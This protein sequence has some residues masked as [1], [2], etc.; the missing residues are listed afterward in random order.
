MAAT[1]HR[2]DPSDEQIFL[3]PPDQDAVKH[4]K[5]R[6]RQQMKLFA[7][8]YLMRLRGI[9]GP[10]HQASIGET[11]YQSGKG[12]IGEQAA[13]KIVASFCIGDKLLEDWCHG[14]L[15]L[16]TFVIFLISQTTVLPRWFN[17]ADDELEKDGLRDW[18][19][20]FANEILGAAYPADNELLRLKTCLENIFKRLKPTYLNLCQK[21][22]KWSWQGVSEANEE[23]T[24]L[25]L[26]PDAKTN[27]FIVKAIE[28]AERKRKDY[29][30]KVIAFD[31]YAEEAEK[32]DF[33]L[34]DPELENL[35]EA[36]MGRRP[37]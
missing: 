36:A 28:D 11:K 5:D 35:F 4:A 12:D 1:G 13:H 30:Y 3:A 2:I 22:I 20:T 15:A 29:L 9:I 34:S 10:G 18:M 37:H 32:M 8:L 31:L 27:T 19:V 7:F 25:Q 24:K 14:D 6:I 16:R 21:W 33:P 23:V 26:K 17:M